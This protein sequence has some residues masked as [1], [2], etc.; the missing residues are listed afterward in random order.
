MRELQDLEAAY[1]SLVVPDSPSQRVGGTPSKEFATVV[2]DPPM[3]SL[4]NSYS[5]EEDPGLRPAGA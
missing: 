4:A 1:P 3:L 5:E 2:H